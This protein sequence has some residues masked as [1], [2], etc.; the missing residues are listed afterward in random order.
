[1]TRSRRA[2]ATSTKC[3]KHSRLSLLAIEWT[4]AGHVAAVRIAVVKEGR[5]WKPSVVAIVSLAHHGLAVSLLEDV[6][7]VGAALVAARIVSATRV[8]LARS[9]GACQDHK[10]QHPAAHRSHP[11]RPGEIHLWIIVGL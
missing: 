2:R 7:R 1:M 9:H 6:L 11:P 4:D 5:G 8:G 10:A 3:A